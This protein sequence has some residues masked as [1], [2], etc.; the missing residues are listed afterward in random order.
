MDRVIWMLKNYLLC[1]LCDWDCHSNSFEYGN[2]KKFTSFSYMEACRRNC[3]LCLTSVHHAISKRHA[4]LGIGLVDATK[5]LHVTKLNERHSQNS[6]IKSTLR[7]CYDC[8][9]REG[10]KAY[11]ISYI[12]CYMARGIKRGSCANSRYQSVCAILTCYICYRGNRTN[13]Q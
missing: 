5:S 1:L 2:S 3:F 9:N 4:M 10:V 7:H 13:H 6:E 8:I 12:A 11:K